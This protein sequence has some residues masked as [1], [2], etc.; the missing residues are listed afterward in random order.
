MG[1]DRPILPCS[2][3][4][5]SLTL[6]AGDSR[7]ESLVY[8]NGYLWGVSEVMPSGATAPEIHWFKLDVSNPAAPTI[9]A[10][11]DISGASIGSGVGVFNASIAVDGNGDVLINF[12]A[13]G[14]SLTPS[15][16]YVTM[17]AG[18]SVFSAPTLYQSSTSYFQQTS[19]ATGAQRWGVY[20]SATADPNNAN[21]FWI[22]N[23]Y[24][25]N[26]GVTIPSGLSAWWSTVTA[27]VTIP[28]AS[29]PVLGNAGN[30]ATYTQGGAAQPLDSEHHR[31]RSRQRQ[32]RRRHGRH[33]RRHPSGRHAQLH[34]PERHFGRL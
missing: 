21:G 2:R 31:L 27:Q 24:V 5:T 4:G 34:Q 8:A 25:T 28:S 15:D 19:G 17:A 12:T 3:R 13:S 33:R 11:G 29:P 7:V 20:S 23:E 30:I 32:S 14:P 10:Q 26:Q 16:Y 18:T 22:S 9:A 6:D 1:P